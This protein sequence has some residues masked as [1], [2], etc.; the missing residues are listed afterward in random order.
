MYKLIFKRTFLY[1]LLTFFIV[2][3]CVNFDI[4]NSLR[5]AYLK[6]YVN[7]PRPQNRIL[8]Y[9]YVTHLRP[10]NDI[11]WFILANSYARWGD[12]PDAIGAYRKAIAIN[13]QEESYQKALSLLCRLDRN[14]FMKW[15]P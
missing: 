14:N 6:Q 15:G 11:F 8:L 3:R 4:L 2:Y 5:L 1:Y 10:D 9:D 12:Y 13:P 7:S